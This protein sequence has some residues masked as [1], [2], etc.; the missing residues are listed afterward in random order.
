MR[1]LFE[2]LAGPVRELWA[3]LGSAPRRDLAP[4]LERVPPYDG[5]LF[6]NPVTGL[7]IVL[8]LAVASGVALAAFGVFLLASLVVYLVLTELLGITIEMPPFPS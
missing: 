5:L 2:I 3:S 4:L 8:T 7:A 6:R 1:E